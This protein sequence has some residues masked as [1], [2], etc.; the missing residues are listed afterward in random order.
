MRTFI[1]HMTAVA[2]ALAVTSALAGEITLFEAPGFGGR[3]ITLRQAAPN[4]DRGSFN[5]RASSMVIRS[6]Y[7][8]VCSDASFEGRCQRFG[9]GRYQSLGGLSHSISSVREIGGSGPGYPGPGGPGVGGPGPGYGSGAPRI[10]LFEVRN[11]G[12]R[13][14]SLT[15]NVADFERIHFNDRAGAAIVRGGVWR[16]CSDARMRGNCREFPPGRYNDLGSLGGKVSSA[17]IVR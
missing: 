10:Q 14:V 12:G 15:S 13:S 17:M 16:L 7:W 8:E 6:G 2:V 1:L 3:S 9:P 5:D 4:F 11:F